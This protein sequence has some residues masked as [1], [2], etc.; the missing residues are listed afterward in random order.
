MGEGP[1]YLQFLN[2]KVQQTQRE[3]RRRVLGPDREV[4]EERNGEADQA[5]LV[6]HE[7][8]SDICPDSPEFRV[9][10]TQKDEV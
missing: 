9:S 4:S 3:K 5:E 1:W 6:Q 10:L 2:S 7:H 8:A